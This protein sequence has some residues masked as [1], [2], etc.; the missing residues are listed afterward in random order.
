VVEKFEVG[1][2]KNQLRRRLNVVEKSQ[3][4][5]KKFDA[6]DVGRYPPCSSVSLW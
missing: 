1:M 6:I 3:S 5:S 2:E 4:E